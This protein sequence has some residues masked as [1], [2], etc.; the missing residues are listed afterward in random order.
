MY[1]IDNETITTDKYDLCKFM[2]F[3]DE[4]VFDCFNSY[5]LHELLNLPVLGYYVVR[6]EE[7]RPDLLSYNIYGGTQY[8]WILMVYNTL[9]SPNQLVPGLRIAYPSMDDIEQLYVNANL[10]QKTGGQ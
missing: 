2:D 7:K 10:Y 4:G 3:S 1:Y 6:A 9:L 5:M 8:W